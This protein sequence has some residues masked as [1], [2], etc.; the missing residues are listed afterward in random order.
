MAKRKARGAA[1][2]PEFDEFELEEVETT[3]MF[4][5]ETTL[6]VLTTL[7]LIGACVMICMALDKYYDAGPL[8]G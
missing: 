1:P 8:G 6:I 5:F 2:E 7:F 4:T 3:P